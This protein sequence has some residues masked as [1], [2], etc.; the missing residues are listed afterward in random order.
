V[1][2]IRG[3]AREKIPVIFLSATG[4]EIAAR[5]KYARSIKCPDPKKN[6]KHFVNF[7]VNL[8]K[9]L[10]KEGVLF[11]IN[12]L[13][14]KICCDYR[15]ELKTTYKLLKFNPSSSQILLN[16]KLFLKHLEKLEVPFP[17]TYFLDEIDPYEAFH[18]LPKPILIKPNDSEL[19][20]R[21]Y[22]EKCIEI[23]NKEHFGEYIENIKERKIDVVLQ[24]IIP[25][26]K[27]YMFNTYIN[28]KGKVLAVCGYDKLRQ[29]PV[30]Y[31]SG[32]LVKTRLD[33][34]AIAMGLKVL[35]EINYIGL[36]EPEMKYDPRD[37]QYKLIEINP[38]S[39]T[40]NRLPAE[41]GVDYELMAYKEAI[42]EELLE[43]GYLPQKIKWVDLRGYM[44][45]MISRPPDDHF[46]FSRWLSGL[47]GKK[48]FAVFDLKDPLPF[49]SSLVPEIT[50]PIKRIFTRFY[51]KI[52]LGISSR[53]CLLR[54]K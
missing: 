45:S 26:N 40:Q 30:K 13:G 12:D 5:S 15:Q 51:N 18:N 27:I 52:I 20:Q 31:G 10:K 46:S 41:L 32:A 44:F 1:G 14:T 24:E 11:P 47:S 36:A 49:L 48:V 35:K 43:V 17:K 29:F 22:K 2:I 34:T 38:R 9:S 4:Q 53:R 25:G 21:E 33:D 3:L 50:R 54:L 23:F 37:G 39:T 6:E 19:F 7:I 28:K 8:G 42:G 16:K